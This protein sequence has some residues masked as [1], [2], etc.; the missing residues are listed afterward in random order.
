MRRTRRINGEGLIRDLDTRFM[1]SRTC[2]RPDPD[3]A[4]REAFRA[5]QRFSRYT[6]LT[7]PACARPEEAAAKADGSGAA[8]M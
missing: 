8:G 3:S 7:Y 4:V 5:A 2:L 6:G 1:K